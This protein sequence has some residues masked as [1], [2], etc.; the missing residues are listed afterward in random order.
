MSTSVRSS[1]AVEVPTFCRICE[2]ECGLVA[3]VLDGRVVNVVADQDNPHSY[4]FMC[5][6]PKA[7]VEI[8]DDPERITRPL[9][10][11]GGPG[12][13]EPVSWDDALDDIATRLRELVRRHGPAC[14]ATH[15]GNPSAYD[16][17]GTLAINGLREAIGSRWA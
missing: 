17:C 16:A 2:V 11:V 6:K 8:T 13:F 4:G 1:Q 9:R 15:A 7:M 5:T 12:E 3:T 10:R 14:F